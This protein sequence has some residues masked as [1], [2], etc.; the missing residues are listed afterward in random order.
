M[1]HDDYMRLFAR[2][3]S[4]LAQHMNHFTVKTVR[5]Q[6]ISQKACQIFIIHMDGNQNS[7]GK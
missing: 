1:L 7:K 3:D 4:T 5:L 2:N 6:V